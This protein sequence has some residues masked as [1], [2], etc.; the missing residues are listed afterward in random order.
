MR[1][2]KFALGLGAALL[3]HVLG[4]R[5][6]QDF[7][8][9][10]DLFLVVVSLNALDGHA[11]AGL[12]GGL[13]A[14]L[15]QDTLTGS[16]Y[17]LYGFANTFVG[18][19]TA[20]LGQR[21]VIQRASGVVVVVFLASLVQQALVVLLNTLFFVSPEVPALPWLLIRAAS[22]GLLAFLLY[23]TGSSLKRSWET[24]RRVRVRKI[25]L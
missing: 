25:R 2:V 23:V 22:T 19:A 16:V 12:L 20:R 10:V 6:F 1:V 8:Q 11:L 15:V 9:G 7:S 13:A 18:Y 4:V 24:R 14:G 17:G 21:L 3:L 5:L